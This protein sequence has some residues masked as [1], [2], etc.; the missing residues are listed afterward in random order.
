MVPG[1]GVGPELMSVVREVF[2]AAEV[3]VKFEE[4]LFSE[5]TDSGA[6]SFDQVAESIQ[7][8]GTCLMGAVSA[9][10]REGGDAQSKIFQLRKWCFFN[11]NLSKKMN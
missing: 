9:L 11:Q 4:I 8:N 5:M 10:Q 3:P 7:R 2:A 1:D 6:E